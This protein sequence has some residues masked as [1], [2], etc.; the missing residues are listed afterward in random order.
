M[1]W[2]I[3]KKDNFFL[4]QDTRLE[5]FFVSFKRLLGKML[6]EFAIGFAV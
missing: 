6:R 5:S 2:V 3:L 1:S 4:L